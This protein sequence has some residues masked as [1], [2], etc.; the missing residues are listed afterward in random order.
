M[1]CPSGWWASPV[2]IDQMAAQKRSKKSKGH[3]RC[4]QLK[5]FAVGKKQCCRGIKHE[6]RANAIERCSLHD[7]IRQSELS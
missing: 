5:G 2:V 1:P 3:H 6:K 4:I 7:P